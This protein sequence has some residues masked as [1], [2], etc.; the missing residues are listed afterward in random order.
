MNTRFAASLVLLGLCV[1][2]SLAEDDKPEQV[3]RA[4]A[5][6]AAQAMVKGDFGRLV[7]LTYPRVV[8]LMGGRDKTIAALEAAVKKMK[9]GGFAFRSAKVGEA[10]KPVAG[11]DELYTVVP[12]TLEMKVPGGTSTLNSFLLG[13][14]RDKGKTWTF[15]DGSKIGDDARMTKRLLPNLPAEL[16]LPK[17]EKPAFKKDE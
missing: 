1:S 5:D 16:K 7:D 6:D 11:G 15:V 8:E 17:K 4:R 13:V 12:L 2:G 9:D 10:S 14:S 3:A